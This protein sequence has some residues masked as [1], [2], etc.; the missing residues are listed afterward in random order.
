MFHVNKLN[1]QYLWWYF[2]VAFWVIVPSISL[3]ANKSMAIENLFFY[4]RDKFLEWKNELPPLVLSFSAGSVW[5]STGKTQNIY[6]QSNAEK[7]YLSN[8]TSQS[9]ADGELFLGFAKRLSKNVHGQFGFAAATTSN[10]GLSGYIWDDADSRFNNYIYRYKIMHT[11]LAIK[12]KVLTDTSFYALSPYFSASAG[13]GF[14][15]SHSF[16]NIPTIFQAVESP[17]FTSN[18]KFSFTYTLGV[19]VQKKVNK[20]WQIGLGY[21]FAD[22]G[23]SKLGRASGQTLGEGLWLSH[24]YTNGVLLNL[25]RII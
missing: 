22:W 11:H 4:G 2:F 14:N 1:L 13:I 5:E 21:E 17:N 20:Y 9:V 7:K 12:G 15:R 24:L 19:G 6:L 18:T 8:H 23:S 3:S 10:A 25:T 16:I